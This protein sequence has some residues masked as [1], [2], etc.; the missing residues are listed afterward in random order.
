MKNR[1]VIKIIGL[2]ITFS[3]LACNRSSRS[4]VQSKE[5]TVSKTITQND[6][7]KLTNIFTLADAE[8]IL[9]EP[10]SLTDSST[11]KGKEVVFYKSSHTANSKDTKGKTGN[12]YFMIEDYEQV[13]SAHKVYSSIKRSN[14]DSGIKTLEGPGDEAYFH[15]DNENFYFILVRKGTK[16]IRIKVN[17]ITEHTSLEE[18]NRVAGAITMAL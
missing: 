4:A 3:I 16:I 6:I 11:K 18:F 15:T 5:D 14:E 10:A 7:A 9:G 13:S 12:V 1:I 8:K 2:I 17:K